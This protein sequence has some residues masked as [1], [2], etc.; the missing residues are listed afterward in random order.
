MTKEEVFEKVKQISSDVVGRT[1]RKLDPN[2][3]QLTSRFIDDLGLSS[4]AVLELIMALEDAYDL[5]E[6]P[7][8]V[9]MNIQTVDETVEYLMSVL[10]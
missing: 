5:D 8:N 1:G 9:I 6:T 10:S 4:I 7:E 3:I 2:E